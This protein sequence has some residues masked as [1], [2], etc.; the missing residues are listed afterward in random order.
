MGPPNGIRRFWIW[1]DPTKTD[2]QIEIHSKD[3]PNPIN[4]S[5]MFEY[6]SDRHFGELR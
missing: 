1:K 6:P 2:A 5:P 3:D 4:I